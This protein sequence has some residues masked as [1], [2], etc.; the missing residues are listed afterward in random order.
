MSKSINIYNDN[1][2]KYRAELKD[3]YYITP[4]YLRKFKP[5]II[6]GESPC[7]DYSSVGKQDETQGREN[8]TIKFAELVCRKCSA[9]RI[10]L[11]YW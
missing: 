10:S 3:I 5:D 11:L 7:Q 2:T 9:S 1:F 4:D 6:V 8:L